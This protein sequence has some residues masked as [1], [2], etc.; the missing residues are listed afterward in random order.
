[1]I[2][3]CGYCI[4]EV[5]FYSDGIYWHVVNLLTVP[6]LVLVFVLLLSQVTLTISVASSYDMR[7]DLSNPLVLV[8]VSFLLGVLP[9]NLWRRLR[10]FA[11]VFSGGSTYTDDRQSTLAD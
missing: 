6:L 9:W 11:D 2:V 10:Q 7:L 4:Y 3:S 1:M 5:R 8:A